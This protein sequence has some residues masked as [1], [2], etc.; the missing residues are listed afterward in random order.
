[1]ADT[2][3]TVIPSVHRLSACGP[4]MLKPLPDRTA[5]IS[6]VHST[7][8]ELFSLREVFVIDKLSI[9]P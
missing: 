5:Y 1:M 4:L 8:I 9:K 7:E 6:Q 3:P 2:G